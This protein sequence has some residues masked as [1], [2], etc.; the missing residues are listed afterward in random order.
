MTET[1]GNDDLSNRI[2]RLRWDCR[3]GML[4]LDLVLQ[5]FVDREFA[6]LDAQAQRA[7]IELLDL[8]DDELWAS[9]TGRRDGRDAR[10][11]SVLDRLRKA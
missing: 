2:R 11:E 7:F 8:P 10:Q 3:R 4:E 6:G 5:R 9:V 1:P